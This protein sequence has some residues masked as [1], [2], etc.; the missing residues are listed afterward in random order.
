MVAVDAVVL[1][2]RWVVGAVS[3]EIV[4]ASRVVVVA[5][6]T[7]GVEAAVGSVVEIAEDSEEEI[8]EDSEEATVEGSEE[9]IVV[10]TEEVSV[11]DVEVAR[12]RT[13][14]KEKTIGHVI[15][16]E[17]VTLHSDGNATNAKLQGQME[18]H[19]EVVTDVAVDHQEEIDTDRIELSTHFNFNSC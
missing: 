1:E 19:Q 7:A 4:E 14:S 8:A 10:V 13:W 16:V 12:T 6:M 18:D 17:T 11:V 15:N 3:V 2:G 5:V 9:E